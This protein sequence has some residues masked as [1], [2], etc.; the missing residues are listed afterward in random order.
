MFR[1]CAR[2]G[3]VIRSPWRDIAPNYLGD[4]NDLENSE[5]RRGAGG[6]GNQ[7]VRLRRAQIDCIETICP[8]LAAICC[9][10]P[11]QT[12]LLLLQA[13]LFQVAL[14]Q[15]GP[16]TIKLPLCR[17]GR[18]QLHHRRSLQDLRQRLFPPAMTCLPAGPQANQNAALRQGE[19][20]WGRPA[21]RPR[22][23]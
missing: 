20:R 21:F 11:W 16:D 14:L 9:Y 15:D 2:C 13:S 22:L 7:H 4:P 18:G 17:R 1:T 19:C 10:E 3:V 23:G 6:H 8:A 12:S 5:D